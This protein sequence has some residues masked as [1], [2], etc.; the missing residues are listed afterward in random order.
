[1]QNVSITIHWFLLKLSIAFDIFLHLGWSKW[2]KGKKGNYYFQGGLATA[3]DLAAFWLSEKLFLKSR[4]KPSKRNTSINS[5]LRYH[6]GSFSLFTQ[7][8]LFQLSRQKAENIN[9]YEEIWEALYIDAHHNAYAISLY[10]LIKREYFLFT[11]SSSSGTN[12]NPTLQL[13]SYDDNT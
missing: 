8:C 5:I 3:F 2:V 13:C 11:F 7:I 9:R 6:V 4:E 12:E 1:M 10:L